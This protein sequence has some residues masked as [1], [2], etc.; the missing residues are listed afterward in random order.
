MTATVTREVA[1]TA[2]LSLRNVAAAA[3]RDEY[4]FAVGFAGTAHGLAYGTEAQA[5]LERLR[6]VLVDRMR[7]GADSVP[8]AAIEGVYDTA[9]M[10]LA[11][12]TDEV[13]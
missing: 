4:A 7:L 8:L 11:Y 2:D 13:L 5:A 12:V 9:K 1:E 10:A 3:S 6:D